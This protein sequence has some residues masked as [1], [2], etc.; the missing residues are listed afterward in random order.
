MYTNK[1]LKEVLCTFQ[2]IPGSIKWDSAFFG[3][4]FEKIVGA[5]FT[6]RE[7]RKGVLLELAGN[8]NN[9]LPQV[10]TVQETEPQMIF[11][12]PATNMAITMGNSMVSFHIVDTYDNWQ[13]F[14]EKLMTPFMEKYIE[15]G[16]YEKIK[17]CQVV[18]LN[19][20]EF[21]EEQN[22]SKYFS[23]VSPPFDQFGREVNVQISK[24]Y[25]TSQGAVLNFR[26][27]PIP[28]TLPLTKSFMLECGA[29]GNLDDGADIHLW[30]E[31]S[32]DIKNPVKAFFE[33]IITDSLRKT[34]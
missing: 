31:I 34:L 1:H 23:V 20:F 15:L 2:F 25:V 10:P 22:I 16:I 18:Y 30:K 13:V 27:S 32:Q 19:K 21:S 29:V 12:N 28:P 4:F 8:K 26:L 3:Q 17:S 7:E 24:S 11:R 33:S 6:A 5:G 9:A 14:N